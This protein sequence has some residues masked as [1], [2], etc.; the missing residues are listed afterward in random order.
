MF[1]PF[2]QLVEGDLPEPFILPKLMDPSMTIYRPPAIEQRQVTAPVTKVKMTR[3]Q[4]KRLQLLEGAKQKSIK[5]HA[6]RQK[7]KKVSKEKT[8]NVKKK[9]GTKTINKAAKKA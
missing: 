6:A 5:V 8:K 1:K 3:K 9:E 2:L 4:K 7:K